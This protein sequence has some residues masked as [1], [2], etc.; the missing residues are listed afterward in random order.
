MAV[1][2]LQLLVQLC[3]LCGMFPFRMVLDNDTKQFKYFDHHWRH[4]ANWWFLLLTITYP[5]FVFVFTYVGLTFIVHDAESVIL[6]TAIGMYLSSLLI[7]VSIPRLF[8]FRFR[9]FERAL[10][11]LHRI[12][13]ILDK[14][15]PSSRVIRRFTIIGI[16]IISA[17]VGL[18]NIF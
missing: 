7:I 13:Y 1:G 8:M 10:E 14:I 5:V 6:Q 12:D 16:A 17:L 15:S 11:I 3:N 9:N 4:P 2:R 18:Y